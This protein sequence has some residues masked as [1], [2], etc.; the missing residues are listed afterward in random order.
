MSTQVSRIV[1]GR[2]TL[3]LENAGPAARSKGARGNIPRCVS[4]MQGWVFL[5]D[6][7]HPGIVVLGRNAAQSADWL[8]IQGFRWGKLRVRHTRAYLY[9]RILAYPYSTYT[10]GLGKAT[11]ATSS[12]A[13]DEALGSTGQELFL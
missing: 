10:T 5:P 11:L 3:P 2:R 13:E 6:N 4:A 9:W 7:Q 8:L 12:P 1:R